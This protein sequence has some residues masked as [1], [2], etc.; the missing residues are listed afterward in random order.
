MLCL[1]GFELQYTRASLGAPVHCHS[2]AFSFNKMLAKSKV[3]SFQRKRARSASSCSERFIFV[4][5]F[6]SFYSPFQLRVLISVYLS[7]MSS[8][9]H[10]RCATQALLFFN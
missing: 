1:S 5:Y 3:N 6:F 4:F 7:Q 9:E 2:E 10:F 8:Q